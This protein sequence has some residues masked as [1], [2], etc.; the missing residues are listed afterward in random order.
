ME[1]SVV[2]GAATANQLCLKGSNGGNVSVLEEANG[3][4]RFDIL[5][6][7]SPNRQHY[8]AYRHPLTRP[9]TGAIL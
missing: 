7:S 3:E 9:V 6:T 4:Y 8:G 5:V 2:E 1:R